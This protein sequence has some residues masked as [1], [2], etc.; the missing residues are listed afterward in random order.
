MNSRQSGCKQTS[1]FSRCL[2]LF[3][4]LPSRGSSIAWI[5]WWYL[6][7]RSWRPASLPWRLAHM[8]TFENWGIKR[9]WRSDCFLVQGHPLPCSTSW[10]LQQSSILNPLLGLRKLLLLAQEQLRQEYARGL[11]LQAHQ[12]S[13]GVLDSPRTLVLVQKICVW[14]LFA[15]WCPWKPA[16][17]N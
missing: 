8:A 4:S 14:R 11:A 9:P 10:G 3:P 15:N 1:R 12:K 6:C 2:L 7:R 16:K 5:W 17:C 13:Q